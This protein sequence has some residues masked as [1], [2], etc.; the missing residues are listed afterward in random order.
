[1][2]E[3]DALWVISDC[4]PDG[5]YV[6]TI[7]AGQ[8]LALTL[9]R[10]QAIAYA[11]T[12]IAASAY[13]EYDAAL[14][15]QLIARGMGRLL[16][17]SAVRDLRADRPPPDTRTTEPFEFLP[18]V[19]AGS[20]KPCVR[21]HLRQTPICEWTPDETREHAMNVLIVAVGVD[22]DAAYRRYLVGQIGLTDNRARAVVNHL[23]RHR[24]PDPGGADA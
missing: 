11:M 10:E 19:A 3:I 6:T 9:S 12:A 21:V 7:Q 2:A 1:M 13:A 16:A 15:A 14:L 24:G 8:D 18:V 23:I 17:A 4:A 5:T 20:L 22:L